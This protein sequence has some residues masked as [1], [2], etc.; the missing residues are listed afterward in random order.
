MEV[1][2]KTMKSILVGLYRGD[3]QGFEV[4]LMS[5]SC[6]KLVLFVVPYCFDILERKDTSGMEHETLVHRLCVRF[7]VPCEL[8]CHMNGG[9]LRNM[10]E[11]LS[12]QEEYAMIM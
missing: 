10:E 9:D 8:F 11:T 7:F 3:D 4:T 2:Q 6:W 12:A 1:L 5:S